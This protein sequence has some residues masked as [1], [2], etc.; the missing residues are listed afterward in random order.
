MNFEQQNIPQKENIGD[1]LK[2]MNKDLNP[3]ITNNQYNR[4]AT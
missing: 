3:N 2:K 4:H 1:V